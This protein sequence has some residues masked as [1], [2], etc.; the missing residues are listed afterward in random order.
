MS[1]AERRA[2]T[3]GMLEKEEYVPPDGGYGWVCTA[4]VF[5]I[6]GHT[7]GV[8]A[9]Y[10]VFLAHYLAKN[11]YPGA[12]P[13]QFAF[14]GGLSISQALFISPLATATV[15]AQGTRTALFI[16]IFFETLS[17]IGA[18]FSTKIWHLF[19]SQGVCFGWGLGFLFVG[20][21]GITSQWFSSRRSLANGIAAGGSGIFGLVYALAAGAMIPSL[22]LPWTYRVLGMVTFAVNSVCS[23]L[24]RD[25][26]A[27]I[28]PSKLAF[29]WRLF[30]RF[31]FI[32]MLGYGFF[33][34]LGYSVLLFSLPNY[35]NRIG[36]TAK[37]ASV[38]GAVMNLG[39]GL[40]RVPIGYW[41]D[42]FG[43]I[44]VAGLMTFLSGLFVL[45][46]WINAKTYA[47]LLVYA[48]IGGSVAGTFWATAGPVT[49]EVV[50]LRELNAALSIVWVVLAVP[51]TFSEPIGLEIVERTGSYLGAQL[52]SGIMYLLAAM[53][54]WFLKAWKVGE[55]ERTAART[56]MR[57]EDMNAVDT[58][59]VELEEISDL[60]RIFLVPRIQV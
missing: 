36:L 23:L 45:T 44:N 24:I 10:G 52:F 1:D 41:S 4:C 42:S 8:N 21:V 40:G 13:L 46:I 15:A 33:S 59:F 43:R 20:S 18:S 55:L 5:L 9:V 37:Q 39:Q 54:L 50:G 17:L 26:N 28:K 16:G 47:V 2:A 53:C 29:D 31:E 48:V 57:A 58:G 34:M 51:T 32:L 35:A 14:I 25:A 19:L 27:K 49:A 6:N 11:T 7:W 56:G 60:P 12:T 3:P 22:G 30:N 38:V